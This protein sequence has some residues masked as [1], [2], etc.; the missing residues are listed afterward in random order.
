M[1]DSDVSGSEV[2]GSDSDASERVTLDGLNMDGIEIDELCDSDDSGRL[3]N[4]HGSDSDGQNWPEFNLEN[5]MSNPR[6]KVG[7][8]FKS[9][10]SLKEAVKQYAKC[11]RAK[12]RA[13]ELIEG[14]HKAQYEKIYE[15]LLEGC[16][17]GYRAG[18]RRIV[19][20]DGC[21]LK[22]Y[23]GGYLLAAVG[24]DA[25]NGIYPL[26]YAAVESENQAS[27]LWFL[28]LLAIDLE[29]VSSYHISFMSD[30]E[31]GLLEA[32]CML[33]PNAETRHCVRHLHS[34]FKNAGFRTKEL[35]DLLWKAA[36]ASITREFDDA[37]DERRKTNHHAYDW[38]KKKIPAHRSRSHFSIRSHS[39]ILVNN[40]SE[41]FN[42]MILEAR[43][44]PILTMIETVRTKIMLLIVKKKEEADKWK[45]TLCPKIMKKLDV[46]IKDSLRF[47]PS[48]AG[49]DKYQVE[50]GPGSQHVV[51][52]V[53]NSCSCRNWDLTG[54]PC[55]H[56]LAVIHV[57]NEFPETYVQTWHTKQTQI[58][59]YSNFVSPVRG[60]KQRASLPNTL[61]ILP[62]PLRRPPGRPTKVRRKEPD[63]PQ[64]TERLSKRG[65]EM[66]C[67]K[68]KII[69]HNKKSCKGEVGQN[70]P[71]KDIKLVS[72]PSNRLPQVSKRVPQLNKVPQLSYLL[73]Q[74]RYL[75]PQ[76]IKKLPSDKSFH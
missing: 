20:L 53:Q 38:L 8:L 36:R 42:K 56:A 17:D 31:K 73:P 14:A 2:S 46:N 69:G 59:I 63:E 19:G 33:F 72:E 39:D 41:S 23:Y 24:I 3:D 62:P 75:L 12:L 65:V 67:S 34:N 47:V 76:L 66:R 22:G 30:K 1:S 7:M 10:H 45:G 6:L 68:C 40:L 58:Q 52:L 9:K 32:I 60:P 49:E 27:W 21:F 5:D 54:I 44:K 28:E 26:A 70:I 4:A 16:K 64:T 55:M 37:M 50:C 48:H 74:L 71:V 43:G 29:I 11:R 18:C 13:L 51:D 15:Y 35:K 25:N 61:P 57:K